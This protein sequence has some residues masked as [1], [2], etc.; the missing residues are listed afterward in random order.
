MSKSPFLE[1]IRRDLRLRGY[2]IRTEKT[3]LYWI[4]RFIL[5]HQRRHPTEM[6]ATEVR[7][8]LTSLANDH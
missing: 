1:A 3:Y 5:Y 8:F 7:A 2:R 6:G 4:K